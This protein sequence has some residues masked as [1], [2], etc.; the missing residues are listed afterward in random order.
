MFKVAEP[1]LKHV[2][3][4]PTGNNRNGV[5]AQNVQALCDSSYSF[6]FISVLTPGSTHDSTE[7]EISA[8]SK[9]LEHEHGGILMAIR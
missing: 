6:L 8:L 5:F 3:S 9:L 4:L 1:S 2:P 7:L